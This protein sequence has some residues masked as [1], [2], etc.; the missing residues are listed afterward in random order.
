MKISVAMVCYNE[1]AVIEK[2]LENA[3]SF[4]DE[5]V[6]FDSYSTDG[7]VDLLKKYDCKIYQHEFDNHRDQKNR[8]IEKCS[9]EWVLLLD[10][11]EY[12]EKKL[13]NN[14]QNLISNTEDI[15]A[16]SFPRKNYIDGDGPHGFPDI[17]TR[18]FRNYV[19]HYG[20]PFHHRA[21]GNSKKHV[22][23]MDYGCIIHEKTL[24]RQ[25]KQNRLYYA[26]RPQDYN[27]SP[28]NGAEDVKINKDETK[29]FENVNVYKDYLI[30]KEL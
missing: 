23:V 28:P 5:I 10:S 14:L 29:D 27:Y 8:T 18:L 3:K 4:A 7:T 20:H 21:D 2:A 22:A 24:K 30:K 17:Q 25:E 11:D 19:R 16:F 1:E 9:N 6:V 26:M 12:L 15:D 13:I